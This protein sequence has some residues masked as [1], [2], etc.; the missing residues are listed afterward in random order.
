MATKNKKQFRRNRIRMRIRKT[1]VGSA[2]RPR[3][4]VFRSNKSIYVQL[5][6]D[7]AGHTLLAATA[8]DDK[9]SKMEQAKAVGKQIAD[10]AKEAGISTVVF[11]R[12]VIC[13]M[14]ELKL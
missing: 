5:I 6:D 3:M 12:E 4:S 7:Q 9:M 13:I 1:V 11:D 2:E 8:D 10:K 14:A